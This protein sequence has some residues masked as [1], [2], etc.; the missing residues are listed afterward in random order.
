LL[1]TEVARRMRDNI[2]V[3]DVSLAVLAQLAETRDTDTGN[4]ILRTQAYVEAFDSL[5]TTFI[6]IQR[7]LADVE[8]DAGSKEPS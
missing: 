3:Q 7:H 6:D 1:E 2:L 4:H 5:R 8:P